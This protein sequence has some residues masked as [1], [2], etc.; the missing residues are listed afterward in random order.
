[1]QRIINQIGQCDVD[2]ILLA[3][4]VVVGFFFVDQ[5]QWI[6]LQHGRNLRLAV[7]VVSYLIL[8]LLAGYLNADTCS[9]LLTHSIG[10]WCVL[11]IYI[12]T[13][14][15][16]PHAE[17]LG[18][19]GVWEAWKP[20]SWWLE[21]ADAWGEE[22]LTG[23]PVEGGP[24][25]SKQGTQHC[26]C[27][28]SLCFH[29]VHTSTQTRD[30]SLPQGSSGWPERYKGR[31]LFGGAVE[32]YWATTVCWCVQNQLWSLYHSNFSQ[33]NWAGNWQNHGKI[34]TWNTG[35]HDFVS[36]VSRSHM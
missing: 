14:Y 16:Y 21:G 19:N 1:M 15:D 13:Q 7:H 17:T 12:Y 22:V 31:S 36:E 24:G 34:T 25:S 35:I 10:S 33:P 32:S 3:F 8:L 2:S 20:W 5:L 30:S 26:S 4:I 9:V 23:R 29:T 18:G 27:A 6:Q 28:V 11:Y